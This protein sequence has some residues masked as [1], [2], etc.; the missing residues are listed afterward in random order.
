MRRFICFLLGIFLFSALFSFSAEAAGI[1][2]DL[3]FGIYEGQLRVVLDLTEDPNYQVYQ[4]KNPDRLVIDLD[5]TTLDFKPE[6]VKDLKGIAKSIRF[7]DITPGRSRI[8]IELSEPAL[9][10]KSFVLEPAGGF[11]WRLVVDTEPESGKMSPTGETRKSNVTVTTAAAPPFPLTPRTPPKTSPAKQ[12]TAPTGTTSSALPPPSDPALKAPVRTAAVTPPAPSPPSKVTPRLKA[13]RPVIVLDPGH[14]GKDP[15]AISI[16]GVYEKNITLAMANELK[17]RL[18]D[19]NLYTVHLTRTTDKTL[20][21]RARMDHARKLKADLFVSIH[22][23]SVRN[24]RTKGLSIYTVS[25]RASDA[26]ASALAE[27]ENKAD[28]IA[29]IDLS[30]ETQEV[31]DILIDLARRETMNSSA[32]FATYMVDEMR[33]SVTLLDNTHRF[34]GFMVL[35]APDVPSVLLEMGY[36]SNTQEEQLLRRPAY[37]SKLIDATTRA[38]EGY[39]KNKGKL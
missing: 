18:D 7:G 23:D 9:I 22:A 39:F 14:G 25:E 21:L 29:G 8:V 19:L 36:L 12:P 27:S 13:S 35:K 26:E 31:T 11:S 2:K 34:A 32:Q 16:S 6:D 4:L 38:V 17:R 20:S 3:R 10:K 37:R 33:K 5:W 30:G 28:L 24:T 1:A 15:G